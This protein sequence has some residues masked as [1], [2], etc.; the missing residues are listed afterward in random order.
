M[1]KMMLTSLSLYKTTHDATCSAPAFCC[2]ELFLL[3][4]HT[5]PGK[6]FYVKIFL[7]QLERTLT[8]FIFYIFI[9]FLRIKKLIDILRKV[10]YDTL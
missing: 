8:S 6:I 5:I 4:D 3:I 7:I 1:R 2:Y 10:F 9:I